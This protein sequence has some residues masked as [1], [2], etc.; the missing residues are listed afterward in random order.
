[1]L[2]IS[3][4]KSYNEL[5]MKL[6]FTLHAEEKLLRLTKAGI[7]RKKV[8]EILQSPERILAGYSGRKIAQGALTN[9]LM[10]RVVYEET[11]GGILVI[12]MYPAERRR[13]E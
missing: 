12:T 6:R 9:D 2:S 3:S 10:L 5:A 13:Y 7:S 11:E 8:M 4:A 1:V